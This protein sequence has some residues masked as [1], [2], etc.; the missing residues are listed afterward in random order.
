[1]SVIVDH[2]YIKDNLSAERIALVGGAGFIGHNLAT[3]LRQYGAEVMVMD[4]L[5]QNNMTANITDTD[6]DGFRRELNHGFL[7][8]RF[9]RMR[10]A[11]VVMRNADARS[12]IDVTAAL[13]E[14]EPTKIVHLAAISS[15]VEANKDPGQCFDLQLLTL[16]NVLEYCRLTRNDVN[17]LV[18]MSSNV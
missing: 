17:Q 6:L 11:G 14:F 10:D 15:A 8:Q 4:N 16:R 2:K 18:F 1:M 7:A 3:H 5:M 9:E 12:T 13:S